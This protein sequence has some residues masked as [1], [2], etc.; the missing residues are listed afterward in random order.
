RVVAEAVA[1]LAQETQLAQRHCGDCAEVLW[2]GCAEG[3]PRA[4]GQLERGR[5]QPRARVRVRQLAQLLGG[6]LAEATETGDTCVFA[7]ADQGDA[8]GGEA[9][10]CQGGG[11]SAGPPLG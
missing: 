7:D 5:G 2:A 3:R 6:E 10:A 1:R 8:L 9:P 11:G 4:G